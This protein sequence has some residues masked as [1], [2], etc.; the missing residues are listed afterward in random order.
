MANRDLERK[1]KGIR[2]D[3]KEVSLLVTGRRQTMWRV[4]LNDMVT[5]DVNV[6]LTVCMCMRI[7]PVRCVHCCIPEVICGCQ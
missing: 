5:I 3:K 7:C 2:K 1:V 6:G 4:R